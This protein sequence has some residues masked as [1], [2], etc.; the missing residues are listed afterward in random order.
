LAA[1]RIKANDTVHVSKRFSNDLRNGA[2]WITRLKSIFADAVHPVERRLMGEPC[3]MVYDGFAEERE[4][5]VSK[6]IRE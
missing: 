6:P 2:A 1:D 4:T 5:T 3:I